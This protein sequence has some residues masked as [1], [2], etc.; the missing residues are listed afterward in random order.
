MDINNPLDMIYAYA[1]QTYIRMQAGDILIRCME[2]GNIRPMVELV[3]TLVLAGPKSISMLYEI[4][5][6]TGQRR[7][8][9]QD[10]LNRLFGEFVR[11]MNELKI[12]HRLIF[13]DADTFLR[14][15]KK[16]IMQVLKQEGNNLHSG[17]NETARLV[18][19]TQDLM[20]NLA[21]N[22]RLLT[23]IEN[24]LRDWVWGLAH[25][26][27]H[28]VYIPGRVIPPALQH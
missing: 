22:I 5:V 27:A 17:Y 7:A 11:K 2:S 19:D 6:E 28:A 20:R 4:M 12:P 26:S 16:H 21:D 18:E 1:E 9:I 15:N 23:E 3:E 8:Q 25:Q 10:D 13:A 14:L 24:L